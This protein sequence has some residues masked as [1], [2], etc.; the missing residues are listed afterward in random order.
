MQ[1][2]SLSLSASTERSFTASAVRAPLIHNDSSVLLLG[3]FQGFK[4]ETSQNT[5]ANVKAVLKNRESDGFPL[6]IHK[7][8][9]AFLYV[10]RMLKGKQPRN[11]WGDRNH[12]ELPKGGY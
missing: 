7:I 8:Q 12:P 9:W 3:E 6:V 2:A 4:Y 1:I 11:E 10:T 5:Y